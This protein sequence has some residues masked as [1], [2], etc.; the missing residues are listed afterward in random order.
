MSG[1]ITHIAGESGIFPYWLVLPFLP[2]VGTEHGPLQKS[3]THQ[4]DILRL[5]K[6]WVKCTSVLNK[7]PT[8]HLFTLQKYPFLGILLLCPKQ[9]ITS[10]NGEHDSVQRKPGA[11]AS[12]PPCQWHTHPCTWVDKSSFCHLMRQIQ[13]NAEII[14]SMIEQK[15]MFSLWSS[16]LLAH[17]VTGRREKDKHLS[18]MY[19]SQ[20]PAHKCMPSE[21]CL[22]RR[23]SI[24]RF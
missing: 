21:T 4:N 14:Q 5:A 19:T 3:I 12:P 7:V 11:M 10:A 23:N 16:S 20:R 8:M 24:S 1:L 6:S 22:G 18:R 9:T 17:V 2:W 15:V 13:Q